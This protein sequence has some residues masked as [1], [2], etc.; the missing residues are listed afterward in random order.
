[1]KKRANMSFTVFVALLVVCCGA[2]LINIS[3]SSKYN[4]KTEFQRMKN[5]YIAECGIDTAVGLF[6]N[7]LDNRD[8]EVSY[9]KNEDGSFS[10][11]S[12]YSPYLLDELI[13]ATEDSVSI[14]IVSDEARNYLISLGY[15]EYSRSGEVDIKVNTF[16]QS[17]KFKLSELCIEP[18]FLIS[19]NTETEEQRSMLNPIYLTVTSTYN[20]GNVLCNVKL[21]EIYAV[22]APYPDIEV[23]GI[24]SVSAFIDTDNIKIE[25]ESYQ[26][27]G[28]ATG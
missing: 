4:S 12:T 25:Y 10:I 1:M 19:N 22:R 13:D 24:G 6:I 16:S 2:A 15:L 5:R 23:G 8:L 7:Y 18:D 26:N 28:G 21:S 17:E 3:V 14:D 27:Y 11:N 20:N 9:T